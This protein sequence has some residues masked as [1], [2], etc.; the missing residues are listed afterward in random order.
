MMCTKK[1]CI[2]F[3]SSDF[4]EGG[5]SNIIL[6]FCIALSFLIFYEKN[7]FNCSFE[8]NTPTD[9]PFHDSHKRGHIFTQLLQRQY[10]DT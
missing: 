1:Y 6:V 9:I 4:F 3:I 7:V 5:N 2:Y 10:K 8:F